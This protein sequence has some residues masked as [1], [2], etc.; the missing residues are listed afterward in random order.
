MKTLVAAFLISVIASSS[1][2][3]I[4][5]THS[6]GNSQQIDNWMFYIG[7][8][9]QYQ[10]IPVSSNMS[11]HSMRDSANQIGG[12]LATIDSEGENNALANFVSPNLIFL[13]ATDEGSEGNW[14]WITGEIWDYTAWKPSHP[15]FGSPNANFLVLDPNDS[16]WVDTVSNL[17]D[18]Q[19]LVVEYE[20]CCGESTGDVN[21]DGQIDISDLTA[22]ISFLFITFERFCCQAAANLDG[23]PAGKADIADMT[24]FIDHLFINFPATSACR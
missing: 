5:S 16:L 19:I 9:H 17:S 1:F 18:I 4:T 23:D 10:I 12:H 13:G 2:S 14:L 22:Y 21:C 11:W 15:D 20:S 7:N 8:K 24:F 3:Q 6:V